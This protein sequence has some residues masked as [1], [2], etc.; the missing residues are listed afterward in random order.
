MSSARVILQ[1]P[2]LAHEQEFVSAMRASRAL[3]RPWMQMPDS[4]EKYAA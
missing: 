3:H 1:P 4:S 2:T